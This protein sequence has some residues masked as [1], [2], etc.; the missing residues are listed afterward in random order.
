MSARTEKVLP[1]GVAAMAAIVAAIVVIACAFD[2]ESKAFPVG[3]MT[4]GIVVA[5]FAATQRNMLLGMRGST[6]LRV[7]LRSGYHHDILAYL[8]H[9]VYAGLFVSAVSFAGFFLGGHLVLWQAWVVLLTFAVVLVLALIVRNEILMA[10]VVKRF[11]EDPVNRS[12]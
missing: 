6:V 3:T 11:L 4:F 9:C 10:R 1:F 5:G 2:P 7:A 8:M 12:D